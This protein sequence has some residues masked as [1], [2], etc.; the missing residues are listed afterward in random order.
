MTSKS[1][2]ADRMIS[3]VERRWKVQIGKRISISREIVKVSDV[4][5]PQIE[6]SLV[7]RKDN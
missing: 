5:S 2:L 4:P 1:K 7:E 6:P 3:R